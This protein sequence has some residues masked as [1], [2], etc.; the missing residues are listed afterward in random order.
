MESKE[1]VIQALHQERTYQD[2]KHGTLDGTGSHTL[3]EWILLIESELAEAKLAL[4]KGG[5]GRDTVRHEVVQIGAL[6][7]A[8]L[9]QHGLVDP[10]DRRQI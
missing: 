4:I 3:G 7:M 2:Q 6:A 9:E 8:C 10:H 1:K 5:R